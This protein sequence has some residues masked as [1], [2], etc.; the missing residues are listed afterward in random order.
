MI[1]HFDIY[2]FMI[3]RENVFHPCKIARA[4]YGALV[5]SNNAG[6]ASADAVICRR[7]PAPVRYETTQEI[8]FKILLCPGDYQICRWFPNRWNRTASVLC[9]TTALLTLTFPVVAAGVVRVVTSRTHNA[10]WT[11]SA[12]VVG[13][14]T[15]GYIT[16]WTACVM[17]YV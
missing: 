4:P 15:V 10:I 7:R 12:H 14:G 1:A 17:E 2:V 11:A 16:V 3:A 13:R 8:F 9:V 6:R 5:I